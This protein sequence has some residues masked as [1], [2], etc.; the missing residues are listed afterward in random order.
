MNKTDKRFPEAST[1][2]CELYEGLRASVLETRGGF[3]KVYG[4]GVI[5]IRGMAA[6]VEAIAEKYPS[7][8][9]CKCSSTSNIPVSQVIGNQNFTDLLINV[10]I[11]QCQLEI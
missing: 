9:N 4:L 3:Q 6:W 2:V 1:N 8:I 10:I 7:E 11:K 5:I